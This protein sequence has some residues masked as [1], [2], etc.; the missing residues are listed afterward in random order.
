MPETVSLVLE[1]TISDK[2]FFNRNI[3]ASNIYTIT[4]IYFSDLIINRIYTAH[5]GAEMGKIIFTWKYWLHI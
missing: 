1:M 3:V 2:P 5:E 4:K